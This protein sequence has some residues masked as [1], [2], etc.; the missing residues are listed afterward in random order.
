MRTASFL[1]LLMLS[2][3]TLSGFAIA[4]PPTQ[5]STVTI[6]DSVSWDGGDFDGEII[7]ANGGELHWSGDV[8]VNEGSSIIIQEGGLLHLHEAALEGEGAASTLLI[9]DGTEITI[10]EDLSDSSATMTIHFSISVPESAGLNLYINDVNESGITGDSEQFTVDLTQALSIDVEH[11]Y[12]L[13]FGI[14]HIE[15]FHSNAELLTI[16]AEELSQQGGN[17]IWNDESFNI[18]NYGELRSEQS[19]ITGANLTCGGTCTVDDSML[20]GS[21]PIHVMNDSHIDI[22]DSTILGSRTDEDVI[23]HDQATIQYT[24]STGTGGYTDAWIRLLSKREII[25]NAPV[26]TITATGIGYGDTTINAVINGEFDDMSTWITDI[27]TSEHKRIVEW[28]DGNGVYH[29]ESG[30]IKVTVDTNWGNFVADVPAAQTATSTIDIVYPKLSIDKVEP[31]AVTADTGRTHGVMVTLSNTGTVAVD[32]N[33]RCYTGD[34]EADT[35]AN[36]GNWA[37]EPGQTKDVPISWYHYTDEAVQLTCKFLYPDSLE[38]V[39]TLIAG[40]EGTTSAE[41]SFTTPEEV[42]EL[43]IILYAAIIVMVVV[44]AG[45]VAV[46]A[47]KEVTKEYV[48]EAPQ[49]E[50][51]ETEEG[52][53]S[54]EQEE[55]L[56]ADGNPVIANE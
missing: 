8:F 40:D 10:D 22:L 15:V 18:E 56:D 52:E 6:S 9:Y 16:T 51:E 41:V 50:N 14:T 26:A 19:E 25:V 20:Y 5:G 54:E 45:F 3:I 32:P 7:I 17:V 2:S 1:A 28:V 43:P 35:T 39:S 49:V 23:L 4:S 53:E 12:A 30:T 24:N 42:E 37:V 55:W 36:T 29:L 47:G 13:P 11:D 44:F 33:V 46:R 21:S 34:T 31:E 48:T 27:G 38:A